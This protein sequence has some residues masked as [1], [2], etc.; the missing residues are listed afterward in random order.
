MVYELLEDALVNY[1]VSDA[2][3]TTTHSDDPTLVR[4]RAFT[5]RFRAPSSQVAYDD[6][7]PTFLEVVYELLEDALVNYVVPGALPSTT[8]SHDTALMRL[9][10]LSC[11]SCVCAIFVYLIGHKSHTDTRVR[12]VVVRQSMCGVPVRT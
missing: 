7:V 11:I 5:K 2:L 10:R 9:C 8:H 3:P 4:F 1:V 6:H 12:E